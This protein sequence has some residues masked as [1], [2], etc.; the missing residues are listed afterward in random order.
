LVVAPAP[1]DPERA[2][3]LDETAYRTLFMWMSRDGPVLLIAYFDR[4]R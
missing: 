4:D 1:T 3:R 2:S